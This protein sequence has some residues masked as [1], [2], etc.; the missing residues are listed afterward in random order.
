MENE[1]Y[2][3]GVKGM[4]WGQRK[5]RKQGRKLTRQVAAAKRNLRETASDASADESEYR[6]ADSAYRKAKSSFA[7]SRTKKQERVDAAE[8]ELNRASAKA[9]L[10]RA[11]VVR[12]N[13]IYD[14]SAKKLESHIAE[15]SVKYGSESVKQISK[16]QYKLGE[17]YTKEM[18]KTWVTV[19]DL[20]LVGT[21]YTGNF[22]SNI[23][24]AQREELLKRR[25][26]ERAYNQY[27]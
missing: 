11:K 4:K 3:Y 13:D 18:I 10:S 17:N 22:V 12:A 26:E 19:A 25:A 1:L 14:S 9:E 24:S 21:A 16:K 27:R 2:H 15:M 6:T 7:L 8:Q 23:E 5:D 20:P